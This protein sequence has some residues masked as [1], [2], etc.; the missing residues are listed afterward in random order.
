MQRRY[1]TAVLCMAIFVSTSIFLASQTDEKQLSFAATQL[2]PTPTPTPTTTT[3]TTT[4]TQQPQQPQQQQQQHGE[5]CSTSWEE[6]VRASVDDCNGQDQ[7][8]LSRI[9]PQSVWNNASE[10]G[11]R[12]NLFIRRQVGGGPFCFSITAAGRRRSSIRFSVQDSS[13]P[14][15]RRSKCTRDYDDDKPVVVDNQPDGLYHV[16][17]CADGCVVLFALHILTTWPHV[18]DD[19]DDAL[20]MTHST[21]KRLHNIQRWMTQR[22][23]KFSVFKSDAEM[24][25][26]KQAEQLVRDYDINVRFYVSGI[27]YGFVHSL[28]AGLIVPSTKFYFARDEQGGE[29]AEPYLRWVDW[30]LRASD[31]GTSPQG[32]PDLNTA[33][34]SMRAY[35]EESAGNVLIT[36]TQAQIMKH[37]SADSTSAPSETRGAQILLTAHGTDEDHMGA[38]DDYSCLNA[39]IEDFPNPWKNPE[40]QCTKTVHRLNHMLQRDDIQA[41]EQF[42]IKPGVF[43]VVVIDTSVNQNTQGVDA[44]LHVNN[45]FLSQMVAMVNQG[46]N[47]IYCPHPWVQDNRKKTLDELTAQG[48]QLALPHDYPSKIPLWEVA[49]V[50]I[51]ASSGAFHA[52]T[53]LDDKPLVLF[54]ASTY[55]A[56]SCSKKCGDMPWFNHFYSVVMGDKEAVVFTETNVSFVRD[57]NIALR[58]NTASRKQARR[59]YF[60]R[61]RGPFDG[62]EDYRYIICMIEA[63]WPQHVPRDPNSRFMRRLDALR[64]TYTAFPPFRG[65]ALV[66]PAQPCSNFLHGQS[67][68][69]YPFVV[70]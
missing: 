49:D 1:L 4:T 47:V 64:R 12:A 70:A 53:F 63:S 52:A 3:T 29:G 50:I 27:E 62:Y 66:D 11:A 17:V 23:Q 57:V 48:V 68:W 36:G 54:R 41:R 10:V 25:F 58:T 35:L 8:W 39:T 45:F 21:A 34:N 22:Q 19:N 59:H 56:E 43:T 65:R 30:S 33:A 24:Q 38:N 5:E 28:P 14:I 15:R 9:T 51:G 31:W 6:R 44:T 20:D 69:G 37:W 16:T 67:T 42:N 55:S 61:M 13:N 40:L 32:W 2:P 7:I 18:D 26:S 60:E 46:W